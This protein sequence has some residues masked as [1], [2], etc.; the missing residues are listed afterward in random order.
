M[1]ES[2]LLVQKKKSVAQALVPIK[3]CRAYR[4]LYWSQDCWFR[5]KMCMGL[6]KKKMN[7]S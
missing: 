7:S 4:L 3:S 5:S 6:W 2:F 1:L